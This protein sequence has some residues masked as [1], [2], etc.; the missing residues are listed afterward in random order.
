M[1]TQELYTRRL[2]RY[3]AALRN[4]KPDCVPIRPFVAEF[5]SEHAGY[6]CQETAHDYRLGFAAARRC[7]ADYDWDAVV[8][9]MIATW[10]G[11]TQAMGLRYYRTPGIDVPPNVGH[12]YLEPPEEDAFMKADEYD[13]LIED[14]TGFLYNV[15]LPRVAAPLS[16]VGGPV[17]FEHNLSLV[18][19]GMAMMEF[20]HAWSEQERRLREETGTVTAI[21]GILKAPLDIIADKLRGYVGM[22]LDVQSQPEKVWRLA[23][24][25]L[26]TCFTWRLPAVIRAGWR[27]WDSGCIAAACRSS[28]IVRLTKSTGRRSSRSSRNFGDTVVRPCS[29]PRA[30]GIGIWIR[31]PNCPTAASSTTSTAATSSRSTASWGT[32]SVFPAVFPITS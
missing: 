3:T 8:P 13:A 30:I 21:A 22:V 1:T 29:T 12:Q 18:K 24:R 20:F 27:P 32:S 23:K 6:T 25:W 7:A 16:A 26:R 2:G 10:T 11:M 4:E 17:T 14:P 9:N 15:W 31:L 19:G 5:T 28:P